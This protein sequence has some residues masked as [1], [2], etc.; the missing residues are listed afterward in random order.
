MEIKNKWKNRKRRTV[1]RRDRVLAA[2][3]CTAFV[4]IT[5][6]LVGTS[7]CLN[8]EKAKQEVET[9]AQSLGLTRNI[10]Q[11]SDEEVLAKTYDSDQ[12]T[13]IGDN[14]YVVN[15]NTHEEAE[16]GVGK[17]EIASMNGVQYLLMRKPT[18]A[19]TTR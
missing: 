9:T 18:I 16:E 1:A 17:E 7:Y 5:T 15:Y 13:K 4:A 11:V 14:V 12:Y 2:K 6:G 19:T 3:I 8:L 10:V